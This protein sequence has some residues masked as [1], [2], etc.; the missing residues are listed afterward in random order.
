M[1]WLVTGG[2]GYIGA[3]VVLAMVQD[4]QRVVVLDDLSTGDATRVQGAELVEGSVL[5]RGLV[6]KVLRE[7]GVTGVVHI[8][9]GA[10]GEDFELSKVHDLPVLTPVDESGRFYDDYG[11]LHGLSTAEVADQIVG[12]LGERGFGRH[13]R[14]E[15]RGDVAG[16]GGLEAHRTGSEHFF[17]FA[18]VVRPTFVHAREHRCVQHR[19]RRARGVGERRAGMQ[20]HAAFEAERRA[21]IVHRGPLRPRRRHALNCVL[22][23]FGFDVTIY[24]T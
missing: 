6:R 5:D 3:H 10:G 8:A 1:T 4:G 20:Q 2:A 7:H 11:W 15:R 24:T 9:P 18:F 17:R 21:R 23:C 22:F 16:E 12:D 13:H 14:D 19:R